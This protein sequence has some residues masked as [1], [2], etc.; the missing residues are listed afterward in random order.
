M[1]PTVVHAVTDHVIESGVLAV[2]DGHEIYWEDWGDPGATDVAICLH[3][4]P[5]S[6]FN[7]SQRTLFDPQR[8]RVVFYDQRGCGR[9]RPHGSTDANLLHDLIADL[10][11]L[12]VARGLDCVTLVGGSWGS[13]LALSYVL[14]HPDVVERMLLWAI[15]LG[16]EEDDDY[17]N[18]GYARPY[19]PEAWER[20]IAPVPADQRTTGAEVMQWYRQR[21]FSED[22]GIARAMALEWTLWESSLCSLDHDPDRLEQETDADPSLLA[23]ARLQTHYFTNGCFI[24]TPILDRVGA[25]GHIP[26]HVAQGRFDMCTPAAGALALRDAYGPNL[27][28]EFVNAGH[29]RTEPAL[30]AAIK[31]LAGELLNPPSVATS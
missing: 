1:Q 14:A 27:T 5:G 18:L 15:Y 30:A 11:R 24:E 8:H 6:G 28:L 9:S 19:F 20:F 12:R 16:R 21:I 4:G 7:A 17:V 31:R 13:T 2:G 22:A 3:G 23:I 26:C 25:I 10:D 29:L